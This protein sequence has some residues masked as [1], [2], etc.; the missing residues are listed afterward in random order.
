MLNVVENFFSCKKIEH[1]W[2]NAFLGHKNLE[3]HQLQPCNVLHFALQ[4]P[5]TTKIKCS[6]VFLKKM[7]RVLG[8]S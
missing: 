3:E 2:K 4:N 8:W 6:E 1:F 5:T 7:L